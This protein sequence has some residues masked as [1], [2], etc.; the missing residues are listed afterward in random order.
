MDLNPSEK[1]R[2][3]DVVEGEAAV[4]KAAGAGV[5]GG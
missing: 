5:V 2:G 4:E 1:S 3:E